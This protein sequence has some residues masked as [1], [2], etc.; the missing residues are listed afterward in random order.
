MGHG[1]ERESIVRTELTNRK[2]QEGRFTVK[3]KLKLW[4]PHQHRTPLQVG[5]G[6]SNSKFYILFL[7][8]DPPN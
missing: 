1:G 4:V 5:G 2:K 7:K 6:L 3:L 8:E